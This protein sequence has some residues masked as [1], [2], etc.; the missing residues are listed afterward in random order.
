MISPGQLS[1]DGGWQWD[2]ARWVPAQPQH[3]SRR[4]SRSWLWVVAGCATVVVLTAAAAGYGIYSFVQGVRNG[5]I[6]C[7]PADFPRYP[8]A[9]YARFS[10]ELNGA[11]PGN[12]CHAVFESNADALSVT[13]FYQGKLNSGAWQV[14]SIDNQ[15]DTISFQPAK[16]AAPFGTVQVAATVANTEI[17]IDLFSATCL[18]LGFPVYPGAKFEGQN[19]VVGG[20]YGCHVVL[21]SDGSIAAITAFYVRELNTGN[22]Q[23]TSSGA[24][25]VGFRLRNGKMTVRS[26]TVAIALS[27]DRTAIEVDA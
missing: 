17:T 18:P 25:Q 23:V 9:V 15:A 8:G 2:G 22:W 1:P 13:T 7:L 14:T 24:G 11:Y 19:V 12:T 5:S 16:T 4:R 10:F 26:G 21:V 6:T 20:T 3:A 27:G